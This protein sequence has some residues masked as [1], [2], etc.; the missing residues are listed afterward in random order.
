M[1]QKTIKTCQIAFMSVL[2]VIYVVMMFQQATKGLHSFDNWLS[3]ILQITEV[4]TLG[5]AICYLVKGY[6]KSGTIYYKLFLV[7]FVA[8]TAMTVIKP[9]THGQT[10]VIIPHVLSFFILLVLTFWKNLGEKR[11]WILYSL[12]VLVQIAITIPALFSKNTSRMLDMISHLML[13]GT[14]G[15]MLKGKY[16]DKK[17]RGHKL[18]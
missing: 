11:S 6:T 7:F 9:I 13:I 17:E 15:F 10:V 3:L 12:L 1:N 18:A 8:L 5:F 2:A 14:Y 16:E 4:L